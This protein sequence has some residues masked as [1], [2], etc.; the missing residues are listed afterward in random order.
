MKCRL[1]FCREYQQSYGE[2]CVKH[3][4]EWGASLE[5]VRYSELTGK[6]PRRSLRALIDWITRIEA[7]HHVVASS[8]KAKIDA[9]K[10]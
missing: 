3:Y 8:H 5:H 2:F 4:G 6:F 10:V 1:Y 9:A 7:E